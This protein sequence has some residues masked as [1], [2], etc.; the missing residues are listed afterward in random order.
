MGR[1]IERPMGFNAVAKLGM[2]CPIARPVV[3]HGVPYGVASAKR[4]NGLVLWAVVLTTAH[5]AES[6]GGS[7]CGQ[8]DGRALHHADGFICLVV[9]SVPR[10][11][12]LG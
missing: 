9:T 11:R 12:V 7:L 5:R 8:L 1:P 10:D 3:L 6:S 2:V 4:G